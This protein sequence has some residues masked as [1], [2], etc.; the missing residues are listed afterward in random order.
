MNARENTHRRTKAV[1][2]PANVYATSPKAPK[3]R[4]KSAQKKKVVD[5]KEPEPR[6]SLRI[7]NLTFVLF[8]RS[9]YFPLC[10][11]NDEDDEDDIADDCGTVTASV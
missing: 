10:F 3:R 9:K 11:V 4:W 2:H 6:I 8:I 7:F 5:K 1:R